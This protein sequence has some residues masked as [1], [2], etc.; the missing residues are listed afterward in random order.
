MIFPFANEAYHTPGILAR[1]GVKVA[2][3][4]DSASDFEK[5]H[6]HHL[7][8]AVRYG[9]DPMEALRAVTIVPAEILR[10]QDRVGSL[11]VGKD[12][13]AVILDGDPLS[14]YSK[15]LFTIVDGQVAY[16]REGVEL[17]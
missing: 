12:G 2:L 4:M 10:V 7:Q 1:K 9:M 8:M 3:T 16:Q 14:T 6:L 17:K 13:D 5:H 15:V 11:E